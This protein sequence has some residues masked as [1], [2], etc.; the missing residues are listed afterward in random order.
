MS[1]TIKNVLR[2]IDLH[3]DCIKTRCALIESQCEVDCMY[4]GFIENGG[5]SKGKGLTFF[6]LSD[7]LKA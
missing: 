7:M 1:L 6:A 5:F 4:G 2:K 3:K